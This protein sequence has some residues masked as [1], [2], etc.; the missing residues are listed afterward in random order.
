MVESYVSSQAAGYINNLTIKPNYRIEIQAVDSFGSGATIGPVFEYRTTTA[1]DVLVDVSAAVNAMQKPDIDLTSIDA[2]TPNKNV[3]NY[4]HITYSEVWTGGRVDSTDNANNFYTAFGVFSIRGG[5]QDALSL[6]EFYDDTTTRFRWLAKF[7]NNSPDSFHT[8]KLDHQVVNYM[9]LLSNEPAG[10]ATIRRR[11]RP[12]NGGLDTIIE[13]VLADGPAVYDYKLETEDIDSSTPMKWTELTAFR[14]I[15]IPDTAV[16]FTGWGNLDEAGQTWTIISGGLEAQVDWSAG[17][18]A[19]AVSDTLQCTYDSTTPVFHTFKY[20]I[21]L[22]AMPVATVMT[23]Q[24]RDVGNS[25]LRTQD[26]NLIAGVNEGIVGLNSTFAGA[27]LCVFITQ[28]SATGANANNKPTLNYF[29]A[30][31]GLQNIVQD[32]CFLKP[33][34]DPWVNENLDLGLPWDLPGGKVFLAGNNLGTCN[35][36]QYFGG[37]PTDAGSYQVK[38]RLHFNTVNPFNLPILVYATLAD[39]STTTLFST[40]LIDSPGFPDAVFSL[41]GTTL[42]PIVG[43]T[44]RIVKI[45]QTATNLELSF[46]TCNMEVN[47]PVSEEAISETLHIDWDMCNDNKKTLVWRNSLGG[48]QSWLFTHTQDI[49]YAYDNGRKFRR[50]VLY[51]VGLST[52]EWLLLQDL[53][54]LG[55]VYKENMVEFS[56]LLYKSDSRVG[57]QVYLMDGETPIGVIVNPTSQ[58]INTKETKHDFAVEILLPETL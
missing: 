46:V 53:N 33:E 16:N 54:T 48:L 57:T 15:G 39:G 5:A 1:G 50:M 6:S 51:A 43:I 13:T 28:A 30:D 58:K 42:Q 49:D 7:P 21:T 2:A 10:I 37:T 11:D 17:H 12:K 47:L 29:I 36:S 20:K 25:V 44:F 34:G 40:T 22:V 19:A 14:N 23:V 27:K 56:S 18:G 9:S 24:F 32:N 4:F 41:S 55:V 45:G 38:F 31:Q 26:I 3:Y 52:E 35:L 8:F